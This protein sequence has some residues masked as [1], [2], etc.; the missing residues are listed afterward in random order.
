MAA[1]DAAEILRRLLDR[2]LAGDHDAA[3]LVLARVWQPRRSR[4]VTGLPKLP[5]DA[6][7]AMDAV[8][9]AVT[10]G[11]IDPDEGAAIAALVRGRAELTEVEELRREVAE[12]RAAADAAAGGGP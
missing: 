10:S 6:A 9:A 8:L 1:G 2:A 11:T 3:A 12:L 5:A 7:G 4:P